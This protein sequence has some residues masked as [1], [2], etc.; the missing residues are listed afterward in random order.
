MKIDYERFLFY[1]TATG[2]AL[3]VWGVVLI[4]GLSVMVERN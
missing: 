2:V 4:L 1:I 3:M